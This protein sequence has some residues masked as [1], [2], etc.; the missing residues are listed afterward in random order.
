MLACLGAVVVAGILG[1]L[2]SRNMRRGWLAFITCLGATM[3]WWSGIT[4]RQ[5]LI[6]APDVARGVTAEFQSDTVIVHNIRDFV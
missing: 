5:D 1:V 2:A 3:L 4:P 6:W